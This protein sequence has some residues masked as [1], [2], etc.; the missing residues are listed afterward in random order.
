M[1]V[2][3]QIPKKSKTSME[4][5]TPEQ[6]LRWLEG[7]AENRNVSWDH[8]TSLKQEI[9]RGGWHA[10]HQGIAIGE[11]GKLYD[12]QHRLWAI[13]EA[14]VAVPMLVTYG[15]SAEARSVIDKGRGRSV[16]DELNMFRGVKNAT[17]LVAYTS[18]CVRL[19]ARSQTAGHVRIRTLN[20]FDAW[21]AA[22]EPGVKFAADT[23]A[24]GKSAL[25]KAPVAGALAFAHRA[26][27]AKIEDFSRKVA[28][29]AG[30]LKGEPA[31]ALRKT[32]LEL[33][34]RDEYSAHE[35]SQRVL[36]AALSHI[37]GEELQKVQL[38]V[39][40]F[41]YFAKAYSDARTL[42][43]LLRPWADSE[44]GEQRPTGAEALA[45]KAGEMLSEMSAERGSKKKGG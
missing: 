22:F 11:D 1:T 19:Y 38:G 21:Y 23:F 14:G 24:G 45:T 40:G 3:Y 12:G 20:A 25:S 34:R 30:L 39:G 29:G 44:K 2:Q 41:R 5:I 6:A 37:R 18:F 31:L 36:Q 17:R 4:L 13:V 43:A 35:V 10:S 7:V 15:V 27:P 28:D 33:T 16:S 9:L 26:N 8:V 32:L 42:K